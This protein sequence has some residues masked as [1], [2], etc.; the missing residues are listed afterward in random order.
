MSDNITGETRGV[1]EIYGAVLMISFSF[2]IA[3]TLIAVGTVALDQ[4]TADTE[5]RITQDAMLEMDDRLTE[6]AGSGVDATTSYTIPGSE[7][8]NLHAQPDHGS[9]NVTVEAT[10]SEDMLLDSDGTDT[11]VEMQLGTIQYIHSSDHITAYQGGAVFEHHPEGYSELLARPAFDFTGDQIVLSLTNVSNVDS[12]HPDTEVSATSL[13]TESDV[14]SRAVTDELAQYWTVGSGDQAHAIAPVSVTVTIESAYADGWGL[15]ALEGMQ[16]RLPSENVHID[17]HEVTMEFDAGSDMAVRTEPEEFDEHDQLFYSG[18][19][20][21]VQYNTGFEP[22]EGGTAFQFN[23]SHPD[24][25]S[26]S[27]EIVALYHH[28]DGGPNGWVYFRG[29]QE[30]WQPGPGYSENYFDPE[31]LAVERHADEVVPGVRERP[32][33]DGFIYHFED[34]QPVCTYDANAPMSDPHRQGCEETM[35]EVPDDDPENIPEGTG[36]IVGETAPP[37]DVDFVL[38]DIED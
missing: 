35:F 27:S 9:V 5:D 14:L 17:D 7:G 28:N 2:I 22:V 11:S 3:L 16:E 19:S 26:A 13:A 24:R 6:I 37:V 30:E 10:V 21:Y 18:L 1:S 38:I 8:G 4:G 25:G 33:G 31:D 29:N 12:L 23:E 15:Y 32:D 34:D 36:R 20:Q